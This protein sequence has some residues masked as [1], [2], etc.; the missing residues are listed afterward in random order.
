MLAQICY[1]F[2]DERLVFFLEGSVKRLGVIRRV[3]QHG[4]EL[5]AHGNGFFG[6]EEL[7]PVLSG[8][9][10]H[11]YTLACLGFLTSFRPLSFDICAPY[12]GYREW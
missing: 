4:F 1:M 2:V 9:N 10:C 6:S 5:L 11:G 7:S 8:G 3:L 12:V